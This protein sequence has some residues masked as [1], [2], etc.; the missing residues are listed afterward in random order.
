MKENQELTYYGEYLHLKDLLNTQKPKSKAYGEESHDEML[1]ILVHQVYELWFKQILHELDSLLDV[2]SQDYVPEKMLSLGVS[3]MERIIKIQDLLIGQFSV[4]ETMT[5]MDFLDFRDLLI[6]ASGFQSVQFREIEVM[7]GLSTKNRTAVDRDF[8][9]GRLSSEDKERV[10]KREDSPSLL[11]LVEKWL[12]RMPFTENKSFNFIEEYQSSVEK[13]L[14]LDE[15]IIQKNTFLTDQQRGFQLKNLEETKMSF[16]AIFDEELHG[17]LKEEG[18]RTL[19][20]KAIVNAL[21]IQLYRD[22]PILSL[23][24]KFLTCLI[25]ID[26]NFTTWRYRH[27]LMARRMLGTKIGT[28]GSSGHE[29]LKI[30]AESNQI[31][32]DLFD[33][34]TYM[35]PRKELPKLPEDLLKNLDFHFTD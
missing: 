30:A 9:L 4:L 21:F 6:P 27:S 26:E 5:P 8:F 34:S 13:M 22:C 7:M 1:F 18:K 29:Y 19:S 35:I 25:D 11:N 32:T 14:T 10:L 33:L 24:H 12:E 31:Y 28:G 20:Q 17:Q 23:P 15:A 3:R 2:F 16:N